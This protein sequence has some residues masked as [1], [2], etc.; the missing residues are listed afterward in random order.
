MI[1]YSNIP[2]LMN[3]GPTSNPYFEHWNT[4]RIY[5]QFIGP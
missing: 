4:V 5:L 2:V 3:D 1:V